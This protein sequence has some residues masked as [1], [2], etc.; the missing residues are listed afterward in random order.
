MSKSVLAAVAT[1]VLV[2]AGAALV[3]FA[4]D[5]A[6]ASPTTVQTQSGFEGYMSVRGSRQGEIMGSG[7]GGRIDISDV[8]HEIVTPHDPAS[9][10]PTGKRQHK[11]FTITKEIDKSSPQLLSALINNE[12]L[13]SVKVSITDGTSN[14]VA[15]VELTNAFVVGRSQAGATE[16]V[17]FV[18]HKIAWT[19]LEGGITAEDDWATPVP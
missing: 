19:W 17:T 13:P 3:A 5:S 14:T 2:A 1:V 15:L 6:T 12:N 4:Q 18:Y 9:G 8:A 16:E 11:P 10:L 7:R